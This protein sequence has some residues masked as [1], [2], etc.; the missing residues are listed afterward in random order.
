MDFYT[1][2]WYVIG[3]EYTVAM[4]HDAI[5]RDARPVG[6]NGGLIAL[7]PKEAIAKS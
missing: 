7:L 3:V 5:Q 6:M 1:K 4:I 2:L